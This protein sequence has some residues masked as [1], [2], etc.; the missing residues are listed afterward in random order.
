MF[1]AGPGDG[2]MCMD[3]NPVGTGLFYGEARADLAMAV[4]NTGDYP[5][6]HEILAPVY[7]ARPNDPVAM[8]LEANILAKLGRREEGEALYM[9]AQALQDAQVQ[10]SGR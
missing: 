4:L 9:R 3:V 6:A 8:V 1:G 10:P 5:R 2:W 7:A